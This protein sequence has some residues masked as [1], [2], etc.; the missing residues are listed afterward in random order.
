MSRA[1]SSDGTCPRRMVAVPSYPLPDTTVCVVIGEVGP[2][3]APA[4]RDALDEVVRDGNRH[5]VV[6][7]S[8]VTSLDSN[9][10]HAL[11][12]ARHQ[13]DMSGGGHLAAVLDSDARAIPELYLVALEMAFDLHNTLA[14]ALDACVSTGPAPAPAP[15][16]ESV[17]QQRRRAGV[18]STKL[19]ARC[20]TGRG[21]A[22]PL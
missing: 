14:G 7:L 2:A 3:T 4:L 16:P 6:D 9:G 22:V 11:F 13:H 20:R 18:K 12:A 8:A 10:L 15:A 21:P 19:R 17:A 1:Q 5:L